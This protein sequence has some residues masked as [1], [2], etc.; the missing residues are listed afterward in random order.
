MPLGRSRRRF[1]LDICRVAASAAAYCICILESSPLFEVVGRQWTKA[2]V[3][4]F[5]SMLVEW[6]GGDVASFWIGTCPSGQYFHINRSPVASKEIA[7]S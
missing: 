3:L 6:R 7:F 2:K 5:G 4:I 1:D